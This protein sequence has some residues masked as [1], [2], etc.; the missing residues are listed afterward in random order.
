MGLEVEDNGANLVINENGT[1]A[2][3]GEN[4]TLVILAESYIRRE[5]T[6]YYKNFSFK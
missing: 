4:D 5:I 2:I 3:K 6:D 1:I